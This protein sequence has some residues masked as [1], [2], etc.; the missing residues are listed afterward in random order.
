MMGHT[1]GV[2]CAMVASRL[3]GP[4][5]LTICGNWMHSVAKNIVKF[6][7]GAS[8]APDSNSSPFYFLHTVLAQ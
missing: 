6:N 5:R 2:V 3:L 7:C 1:P 8:L 4:Q